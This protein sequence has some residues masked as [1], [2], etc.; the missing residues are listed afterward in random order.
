MTNHLYESKW[1]TALARTAPLTNFCLVLDLDETLVHSSEDLNKLKELGVL[2]KS[3]M[4]D[5]LQ[6][7][8]LLKLDDVVHKKGQGIKTEMWGVV[9]PHVKE[10]L[11]ACFTYFKV[12]AVWSAGK[13]KYVEAI[14]DFLFR[15][16]KRPH[17]IFSRD[18]CERTSNNTLTK[19]LIKMMEQV[20]GLAKYMKPENTFILDDRASV[21]DSCNPDNGIQIPAYIPDFSNDSVR[22]QE[23]SLKKLMKWFA[24]P[25]VIS[26][27]D[28]RTLDKKNI[29][30]DQ[31]DIT[32]DTEIIIKIKEETEETG[33][34]AKGGINRISFLIPM[35]DSE[36]TQ[37]ET[38]KSEGT[39]KVPVTNIFSRLIDQGDAGI[40]TEVAVST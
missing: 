7:T 36:G 40:G 4:M 22:E 11:T 21:F 31:S 32:T 20:P 5:V 2:T 38:S 29:F 28:I 1:N 23:L 8:Y 9:R 14:V 33:S 16:I 6:N 10:F 26:S 39:G 35:A 17:V 24:K 19:P 37:H 27:T 13:K 25:E 3:N 34:E 18:E 12:V 15:D 30:I